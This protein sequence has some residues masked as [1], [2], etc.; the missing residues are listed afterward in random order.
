MPAV[1]PE[2]LVWARETAGL[3]IAAAAAKIGLEDRKA[4]TAAERLAAMESGLEET[5]RSVL[6]EMAR[7]YH[8]PL[9]AFYLSRP[10][11]KGKRGA[12]FRSLPGAEDA[13]DEVLLDALLRDIHARQSMV[14][15][16][17]IEDEDS[18]PCA[19]V[20][21]HS[22]SDGVPAVLESLRGVLGLDLRDY[23]KPPKASAAFD[24]LRGKLEAAGIFVLLKGDLGN[25]HSRIS[26]ESFRGL[27]LAD[28]V[29]PFIVI[30][31][32]D[33]APAHSF[34]LLHEAVHL[35]LGQTGVGGALESGSPEERF[36]DEVAADFLL[37]TSELADL[38]LPGTDFEDLDRSIAA[39]ADE[40]NLSRTMVALRMAR[41]GRIEWNSYRHLS[42]R[43]RTQW[44]ETRKKIVAEVDGG[45]D[46][47][48]VRKRR[49]GKRLTE[50]VK[51]M[52]S[53]DEISTGRA[54][55][56]LGVRAG[57]VGPLLGIG[58]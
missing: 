27:S 13:R 32:H 47:Y 45:P 23:R 42:E 36:C 15:V 10:P 3:T 34:T 19:F 7:A 51:T 24:L 41:A 33:A 39:F 16:L 46:F 25:H 31:D 11:A 20:G 57:Q 40:R 49:L 8:R 22:I 4:V 37:P 28:P 55:R 50:V 56:I 9:I 52:V 30:H 18:E 21:S 58:A 26:I 1:K 6:L 2:L 54:A 38:R 53:A 5:S 35:L 29:A 17:L 44:I 48:V 43:W 14:R 12:D